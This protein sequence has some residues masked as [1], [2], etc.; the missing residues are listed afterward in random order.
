MVSQNA[1]LFRQH[2]VRLADGAVGRPARR[3]P[4]LS[5]VRAR[6]C[7]CAARPSDAST[8]LAGVFNGSPV[9]QQHRRPAAAK[10]VRHQLS[11]ERRRAGDRRAAIRLSV[12][13]HDGLCRTRREPLRAHLQLGVWYDSGKFADQRST[14]PA[15]RSPAPP[16]TAFPRRIAATFRSTRWPTRCSG[17]VRRTR[18]QHQRIPARDGRAGRRP[19]PDQLQHERRPDHARTLPAPRRRHLRHRHGL[20]PGQRARC[21]ARQGHRAFTGAD[22]RSAAARP[23]SNSPISISGAVAGVAAGRPI[24]VRPGRRPRS[25]PSPPASASRTK[26]VFGLRTTIQF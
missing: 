26:P 9:A 17:D 2:D 15:C 3:R 7:G 23:S 8:F 14:P 10:C 16:A 11:A 1:R 19:Q 6:A 13:G 22:V 20:R 18:P 4:G 12:T 21:R 25:T 5:A 24:R